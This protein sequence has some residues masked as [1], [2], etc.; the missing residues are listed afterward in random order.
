MRLIWLI[1]SGSGSPATT[2]QIL[3][4]AE[5]RVVQFQRNT[6]LNGT[7]LL[8]RAKELEDTIDN[9]ALL[10]QEKPFAGA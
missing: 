7:E 9:P 5:S 10:D 6:F 1:R 4:S 3:E 8:K 2:R